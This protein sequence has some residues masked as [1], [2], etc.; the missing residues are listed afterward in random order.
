MFRPCDILPPWRGESRDFRRYDREE[1]KRSPYSIKG[2]ARQRSLRLSRL[3]GRASAAGTAIGS[4]A[5]SRL[6]TGQH[7]RAEN[8]ASVKLRCSES[9]L[10]TPISCTSGWQA[11]NNRI[12]SRQPIATKAPSLFLE[13]IGFLLCIFSLAIM[14]QG[15]VALPLTSPTRSTC[16]AA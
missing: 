7:G 15:I 9:R 13:D 12:I 4:T 10:V 11:S 1:R 6:Y 16:E 14:G 8:P 5:I 2:N 3:A